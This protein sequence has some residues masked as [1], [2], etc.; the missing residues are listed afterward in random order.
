M[1]TNIKALQ[2]TVK[3]LQDNDYVTNVAPI[4]SDGK[5]V[6]KDG[7][8]PQLKIEDGKWLISY[9]KGATW[10]DVG[11]ATGVKAHRADRQK[12]LLQTVQMTTADFLSTLHVESSSLTV[13]RTTPR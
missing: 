11:Q 5:E 8:T 13:R 2:T 4:M 1:N 9:D 12:R 10:E 6:G 3:A 7:V